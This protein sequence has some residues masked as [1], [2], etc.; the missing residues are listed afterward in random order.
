MS[1]ERN[2]QKAIKIYKKRFQKKRGEREKNALNVRC[3]NPLT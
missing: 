3:C 1:N 2:D